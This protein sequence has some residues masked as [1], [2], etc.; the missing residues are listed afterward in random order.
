MEEYILLSATDPWLWKGRNMAEKS[1]TAKCFGLVAW[2]AVLAAMFCPFPGWGEEAGPSAEENTPPAV[3]AEQ[4]P[5]ADLKL[6][7]VPVETWVAS[8]KEVNAGDIVTLERDSGTAVQARLYGIDAPD[9]G[10]DGFEAARDALKA[11][12]EGKQVQ[13]AVL[14]DKD[15]TGMP[16][17]YLSGPEDVSNWSLRMVQDGYAWW[18]EDNVPDDQDLKKAA[19]AAITS[20]TGIWSKGVPLSPRDFRRSH[21]L[22]DF[23]YSLKAPEPAPEPEKE[24]PKEEIKE[25]SAKG[26]AEYR[27]TYTLPPGTKWP[28]NVK[29]E[30]LLIK[31]A[32]TIVMGPDGKPQ[33]LTAQ[34]ISQIPFARELGL[35]DGDIISEVNGIPIQSIPQ[36]VQMAPQ[37]QGVRQFNVKILR[38][39]QVVPLTIDLSNL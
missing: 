12:I 33:G 9:T 32:P 17:I 23:K 36:I 7:G 27:N 34:N 28:E 24:K 22:P 1:N 20:G 35:Q 31:H 5:P 21:R 4:S 15:S 14:V 30:D 8:V 25:L 13:V 37:F 6:P 18:D 10:Q 11:Q 29:P 38:N 16:V 2:C 19:A 26:T 3:Q 39:G